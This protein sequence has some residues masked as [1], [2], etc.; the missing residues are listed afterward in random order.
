MAKIT[1]TVALEEYDR[2][3]ALIDGKIKPKD[4]DL[5]I[6]TL[7]SAERHFRM[8]RGN[9][10]DVCELS[11]SSY[12]MAKTRGKNITG[13]PIFPRRLF[14]HSF[15]YVNKS[16]DLKEPRDLIGR[17]V[18]LGMY[19]VTMSLL[20]KGFLSHEFDVEPQDVTWVTSREELIPFNKPPNV[21]IERAPNDNAMHSML[22]DGS[23]DAAIYPDVIPPIE[24]SPSRV[25]RLFPD[26]KQSEIE[27]YRKTKIYPIM[28]IIVVR[29]EILKEHPW[30]ASSLFGAFTEAKKE[31]YEFLKHPPNNS[32]VWS[33]Y[34]LDEQK[35]ILGDDPFPYGLDKN[36]AAAK[37]LIQYSAEQGLID[38]EPTPDEII[39]NM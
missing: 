9:E 15:I 37:Q 4:M 19:Q 13:L 20:A 26:F 28:H 35:S 12:I 32:I 16:K 6:V 5:N 10:F 27:Y 2:T 34:F 3:K 7:P 38:Y 18:G 21:K 1:L 22:D 24:K 36:R 33:R 39:H 23:I 25:G 29:N 8:L 31:C 17:R 11:M 14:P 30:A